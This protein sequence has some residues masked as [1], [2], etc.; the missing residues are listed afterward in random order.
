MV[1]RR[2]VPILA[3]LGLLAMG[4]C[5]R[6]PADNAAV[7]AKPQAQPQMPLPQPKLEREQ[8]IFAAMRAL[9]AAALH[10]DDGEA[11]KALSG[12]EFEMRLRFGCPGVAANPSR[13][14]SYDDGQHVVRAHVSADLAANGVP[15]SDLLLKGYEGVAGFVVEKPLL[16]TPGCPAPQFGAL[17]LGEPTIAVAQLFTNQDSRVQRPEHSY[18][19]TKKVDP[20]QKP[21]QGLDLVLSGRLSQ[22]SDGRVV[23]CGFADGPP[24]CVV[25]AKF[26]RIAIENPVD[27]SVLG[28]WSNW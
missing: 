6:E 22:L 17:S 16:L 8:L 18:E 20:A 7:G 11:Q 9:S 15:A 5:R 12:R 24:A 10:Q 13:S 2:L 25:A 14:W 21:S 27:G 4:G 3:A 28:E 19:I 23:H 1:H 26:D